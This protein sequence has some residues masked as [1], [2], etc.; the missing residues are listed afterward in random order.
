MLADRDRALVKTWV[1]L[2]LY[3]I[4]HST[5]GR[6]HGSTSVLYEVRNL[7]S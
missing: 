7:Y 6:F 2:F 5:I 1:H 3:P 4:Q